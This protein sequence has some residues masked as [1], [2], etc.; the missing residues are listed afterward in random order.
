M[1]LKIGSLNLEETSLVGTLILD[2]A[3]NWGAW[4]FAALLKVLLFSFPSR[5]FLDRKIL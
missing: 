5:S 2:F 4:V 3:I 1:T